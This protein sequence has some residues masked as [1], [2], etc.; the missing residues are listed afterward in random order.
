MIEN[1]FMIKLGYLSM[2]YLIIGVKLLRYEKSTLLMESL[3]L[4]LIKIYKGFSSPAGISKD[5]NGDIYI[6]NWN[7]GNVIKIN[8]NDEYS[9][10]VEGLGSPAGLVHDKENNLYVADYTRNIIYKIKW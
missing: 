10:F 8:E 4:E 3:K 6:S 2:I 7:G 5:S 1:K 9:V